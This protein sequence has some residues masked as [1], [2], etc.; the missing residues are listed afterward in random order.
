M[1][2]K[3]GSLRNVADVDVLTAVEAAYRQHFEV[4]PARASV[5]FLGVEP[6]EI[7][8][9]A[10][11]GIDHF[12]SLGMSRYPMA[13]PAQAVIDSARSPRGELMLSAGTPPGE[14]WKSLAILAAAPAVEGAVYAVG[15]RI[16]M[17]QPLVAGSRCTGG[18]LQQSALQPVRVA[19][20]SD[21]LVLQVMPAT[22]NELAWARVHG[23][24]A[25]ASRWKEAA[26]ELT[27][28]LRESVHLT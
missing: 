15:N 21:V 17:G 26:T 10:E 22:A 9:Y 13:D 12:L 7:L 3:I 20:F 14:L 5:S 28:L 11:G 16:D 25:L 27:D 1:L 19:G 8:R 23:S 24:D 2:G 4:A 18:I 6:I